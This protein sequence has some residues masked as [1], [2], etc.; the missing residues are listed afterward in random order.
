[1]V[2]LFIRLRHAAFLRKQGV[3]ASCLH[4]SRSP[5][6]FT[7]PELLIVMAVIAMLIAIAVPNFL[8]ARNSSREKLCYGNMRLIGHAAEHYIINNDLEIDTII[9][10]EQA[11]IYVKGGISPCPGGGSYT[12]GVGPTVTCGSASSHGTYSIETGQVS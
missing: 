10:N 12:I 1:M 5:T 6:G 11:G 3:G 8:R 7:L 2:R 9:T 4:V